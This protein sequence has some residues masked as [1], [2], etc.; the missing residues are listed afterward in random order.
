MEMNDDARW[1]ASNPDL[2][3]IRDA[4]QGK[5]EW[6]KQIPELASAP[7]QSGD[8]Y[9]QPGSPEFDGAEAHQQH[10]ESSQPVEAGDDVRERIA[11]VLHYPACWDTAAYPTLESAAW[12]AIACAKLGCSTCE[13]APAV[14]LDDEQSRAID[15]VCN[16]LTPKQV[17]GL[18]DHIRALRSIQWQARAASPQTKDKP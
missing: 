12:E 5:G 16:T 9:A 6:K 2:G 17:V 15:A 8:Q 7:A 13:A 11:R 1:D 14:V 18:G 10:L 4:L 3:A